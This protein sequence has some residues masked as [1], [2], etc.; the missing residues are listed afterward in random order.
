MIV[1]KKDELVRICLGYTAISKVVAHML[2]RSP[3]RRAP[4]FAP[5]MRAARSAKENEV[6]GSM[7]DGTEWQMADM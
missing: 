1:P 7:K 4:A 5:S 3:P 2:R 6:P